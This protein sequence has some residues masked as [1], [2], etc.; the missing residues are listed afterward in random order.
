MREYTRRRVGA[1]PLYS[2]YANYNTHYSGTPSYSSGFSSYSSASP[3]SSYGSSTSPLGSSL[4][5]SYLTP[6]GNYS[7]HSSLIGYSRTP[8]TPRW[9]PSSGRTYSPNLTTISER[10][11][12]NPIR[13]NSPRRIP[14]TTSYAASTYTP[15]PININTADIDVSRD[16]YRPK[17]KKSTYTP[18]APVESNQ[19]EISIISN[20]N[21]PFMP[22]IDG[23]PETGI[24]SSPGVSQRS[25]LKRGRTVVRLHTLKRRERDSPRKP[26]ELN[27]ED[28]KTIDES[29]IR[30]EQNT[31]TVIA[32]PEV[33]W[34]ERL[35][36]DL[37]YKDKREKKTIGEK[38][39]EKFKIRDDGSDCVS[40]LPLCIE[41]PIR[42]LTA[43][44][45]DNASSKP[46]PNRSPDR[47]CSMELLA[48]QANVLDSLIRSENLS[49]ASL[50]LSKV[51]IQADDTNILNEIQ[52]IKRKNKNLQ[53]TKSDYSLHD[54]VK[55]LSSVK[56]NKTFSK[57]KSLKKSA[58][59]GSICRLDSITELTK[60]PI[61]F[62]LPAIEESRISI[63]KE[64]SKIKQKLKPKITSTVE[65]TTPTNALK[66]RIDNVT[67]EE[68]IR[69]PKKGI[70]FSSIVEPPSNNIGS[71][72]GSLNNEQAITTDLQLIDDTDSGHNEGEDNFWDKIGK[73]ETVYLIRRKQKI[74]DDLIKS[75]RALFWQPE[76]ESETSEEA[77]TVENINSASALNID[78]DRNDV[79]INI[80]N[81]S[82]IINVNE[83]KPS[84]VNANDFQKIEEEDLDIS[85]V[86]KH[87]VLEESISYPQKSLNNDDVSES[88]IDKGATDIQ[89]IINVNV[90]QNN[91]NPEPVIKEDNSHL[92]ELTNDS[93]KHELNT[94]V[95][96]NGSN[97]HLKNV[98]L[99]CKQ[100]AANHTTEISCDKENI[101]PNI[102]LKT[103]NE[104]ELNVPSND[105]IIEIPVTSTS[106]PM[107]KNVLK[108]IIEI[109][110]DKTN[111]NLQFVTKEP[112]NDKNSSVI[113]PEST[114]YKVET[115]KLF[116]NVE[117]KDKV[118][119]TL[120]EKVLSVNN[121]ATLIENKGLASNAED[122]DIKKD[123]L[124]VKLKS[125]DIPNSKIENILE[126]CIESDRKIG[127]ENK[128]ES[129][130]STILTKAE[131]VEKSSKEEQV[132][133][134]SSKG[135][136]KL[137]NSS[138]RKPVKEEAALRPLIATPRPLLKKNPQIIH[139]SSSSESS[140]EDES[141]EDDDADESDASAESLELNECENN[142][143]GRTSTG[144]NDSGFDSSAPTSPAGFVFI[145][146][147]RL[148]DP[149]WLSCILKLTVK[150]TNSAWYAFAWLLQ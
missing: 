61:Q 124:D 129:N 50:D 63:K 116:T 60:E 106:L 72:P 3:Y 19:N 91:E 89:Q 49:T 96:K 125:E 64:Q 142:P 11:T 46:Q 150:L 6:G 10:S 66:F 79:T 55:S 23:K 126:T 74:Q 78:V 146:K 39:I 62:Q 47:R 8:F 87:M 111:E 13:I 145:K 43:S 25:T 77:E 119:N 99:N 71:N 65:V 107:N 12:S 82:A 131:D 1:M 34:R 100:I 80:S 68:K 84:E 51:G 102:N 26:Q 85:N 24:D 32:Q 40:S 103:E 75:R 149:D 120:I 83:K 86:N 132:Q 93:L 16:R 108:S 36:E 148:H 42:E 141:S 105:K 138:A 59:G 81:N 101:L 139:S 137:P 140:S 113:S 128:A 37:Q 70:S 135:I 115:T 97:E 53:T 5:A 95:L 130:L 117:A 121:E 31:E 4:S 98:K 38:L 144:S 9:V 22:R 33:S 109:T 17:I 18:S 76:G 133:K 44:I 123:V 110:D 48:E 29:I 88:L 112:R 92:N 21:E 67:V 56:D 57:R 27:A 2:D 136:I 15:R 45:D 127:E 147:G 114:N 69:E 41:P 58:S 14:I 20:E 90:L 118:E 28:E 7:N 122:E 54:R 143:D 94:S 52:S 73:R 30:N 134:T 35:S 104:N